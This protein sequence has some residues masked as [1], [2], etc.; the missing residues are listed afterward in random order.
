MMIDLRSDTLTKPCDA[1]RKEMAM[2]EV[3]DDVYGEDPTVIRLEAEL[4]ERAGHEAGLFFPSGTQSNLAALLAHCQRG[5]E[6][7][8]GQ[9]AHTY[10]Y[11]AGGAAVLGSIQP[12]PIEHA[13][14]GTIPLTKIEAAIKAN[15]FHFARSKLLALENTIGGKVL[16]QSYLSQ[17]RTLADKHNLVFHLD[18]ARAFN[19][20][21]GQ[22]LELN[23]IT[24]QFD[25]VSLCLSK[26][27]GAP[28]GS[29]LVAE[30][31]VIADARR[32]RK[33]VGGGM[34][35]AGILAAAG[36]FAINH[37]VARLADDHARAQRLAEG[38]LGVNGLTVEGGQAHTNMVYLSVDRGRG[39]AFVEACGTNGLLFTG[40]ETARLVIHKDID[41]LMID[42]AISTI[43]QYFQA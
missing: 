30:T 32:W 38:L 40:S 11:E 36:L 1:M 33:M 20:A 14:D 27:L 42:E 35:Q 15:D 29:V 17:A 26:G 22:N 9:N 28:I 5:D 12:Q 16:P 19:A 37:N 13:D 39:M 25:S 21:V 8:V 6:Y 7:I 3:G 41:D 31:A 24:R 18:G 4:A 23:E 2:A 34:R 43:R 10:R